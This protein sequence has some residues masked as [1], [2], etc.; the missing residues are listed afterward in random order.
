[1]KTVSQAEA[2]IPL[3]PWRRA[4]FVLL[5]LIAAVLAVTWPWVK[6]FPNSFLRHWDPPFHAWKLEYVARAILAGHLL[7][8]DGNTNMYYPHSGTLYFEALHWPQ[9]LVAAPLF[10]LFHAS[11]VLVYHLVLVFFWALAGVCLW[12]LLLALGATRRAALLGALIFTIMPYRISYMVEFNMQLCFG[13]PLFFFFM[14]RFFQHPSIRYACGM[15]LAWWLQAVSELYQAVFL[16]LI[17]P[18]PG[19]ALLVARRELLRS[20]RRFWL[21]VICAAGLGGVLSAV[22]L[23]PYLTMLNVHAVNRNLQEI[24]TH[25]LEPLSYLRPGGRFHFLHPLDARRD[26]M[27]VYPTAAL[28]LLAALYLAFD[29]RRLVRIPA[30]RW[31]WASRAVRWAALLGFLGLTFFIYLFGA[32]PGMG[33]V[34]SILPVIAALFAFLVL[35]HPEERD[36]ASLFVTGLFAGAVFAFFMSLGPILTIRHAGF[37][38]VNLLYLWIYKHLDALHGFR[39]VSRF[40]I[41]LLLYLVVAAALAWSRIERQ[42]LSQR[43]RRWLWLLPV[44]AV[45]AESLPAGPLRVRSV[46]YPLASATLDWLDNHGQPCVIAMAPMGD[47]NFDSAHMLQ[48][49]RTERLFVYA[50]GG[51]YPAYTTE[52]RTALDAAALQPARAAELLRQLWPEC[53]ILEDKYLSRIRSNVRCH[54]DRAFSGETDIVAED[55][56]FTLLRLKP[57][58]TPVVEQLKLIR[59]DYLRADSLIRFRARTGADTP[60]AILWLDANGYPLGRWEIG[61]E[62]RDFEVTVP[63]QFIL[64]I[65]PNRLRFHAAGD[66]PFILDTFQPAP[67]PADAAP[68]AAPD[69]DCPPWVGHLHQVPPSAIRLEI[70]YRNGFEYLACE[71]L[72]VSAKIGRTLPLRHYVRTSCNMQAAVNTYIQARLRAA[73]GTWVESSVNLADHSDLN[74]VRCQIHPGSIYALD[75]GVEL[76]ARLAPGDYQL[77]IVLR[78][79]HGQRLTGRHDG[80]AVKEVPVPVTIRLAR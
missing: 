80:K 12:M 62:A 51:A 17:L 13:L 55:L 36:T 22:F 64:P 11:P 1:M 23:D 26:E 70:Q 49:A 41:Y 24:A 74:D 29:A 21:P 54:F 6:Y 33:Q 31:I 71:P 7:P 66:V 76:P 69:L 61:P 75:Q 25:I 39:V 44:L 15:A 2:G 43:L 79:Q 68:A 65:L 38:S 4:P 47:R 18:F 67:L 14:V 50:W 42:W 28:M 57:Q 46:E 8:P 45:A 56:R 34:Y 77:S 37:S 32:W 9:A 78:N 63:P 53:F 35:L 10:G 60:A 73:D 3:V 52:V 19:F 40:S 27:I 48:I 58:T 72:A 20:F 16:L 30:P 59:G 5:V